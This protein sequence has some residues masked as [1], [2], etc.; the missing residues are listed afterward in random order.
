MAPIFGIHI[1]DNYIKLLDEVD[2]VKKLG[3]NLVQLFVDPI[4]KNRKIYEIFKHKLEE[5]KMQCVVHASYTINLARDWDQYS[6]WIRQ[7]INEIEASHIIGAFGI[8]VHMGKQLEMIKEHAINNMYSSLLYIHNQTKQYQSVKI[9]LETSTGQGTEMFHQLDNFAKFFKKF[10]HNNNID[11]KN[12]FRICFD[13]CH[14]FSAGYDIRN[15]NKINN[16]LHMF[17]KLIGIRY[18]ALIHL[19][20]SKTELGSNVD[21]HQSLGKGYIGERGLIIIANFFKN[22]SVPIV[23]ETPSNYH[24]YEVK[25]FL[26]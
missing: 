10:S 9:L 6:V 4:I 13:T 5:N 11:I 15:K 19:N 25:Q 23:L 16:Y 12:R 21:R 1:D 24:K 17:E 18:I 26:M 20:D 2:R 3:C 14:I 22:L 7:L 8:V